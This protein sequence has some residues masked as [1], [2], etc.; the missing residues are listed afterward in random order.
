MSCSSTYQKGKAFRWSDG[1]GIV[2]VDRRRTTV[3]RRRKGAMNFGQHPQA[4]TARD[5]AL[6]VLSG[7]T[8]ASTL[9]LQGHAVVAS[10]FVRLH[11]R[12]EAARNGCG[13]SLLLQA[14]ATREIIAALG[15]FAA[16]SAILLRRPGRRSTASAA[17]TVTALA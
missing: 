4:T 1:R 10:L 8:V 16:A 14:A 2:T 5:G 11:E 15:A 17:Q 6:R 12:V 9:H 7:L 3:R 13:E